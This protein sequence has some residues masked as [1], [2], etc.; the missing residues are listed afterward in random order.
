MI[1]RDFSN[2]QTVAVVTD[3][4]A[5]VP[6]GDAE[7]LG[8]SIVPFSVHIENEEFL[9]G[10]DLPPRLLYQRMC[11]EKIVPRTSAPSPADYLNVFRSHLD[12]GIQAIIQLC[13]SS[14]LSSAYNNACEAAKRA[15]E[16][17]PGRSVK[18][19]DTLLAAIPQGFIVM[20]AAER[21]LRGDS[22]SEILQ[23]VKKSVHQCGL[24]A[25]PGT[26]EYLARGGRIGK[27]AFLLGSMVKI[28]PILTLEEGVVSPIRN[29]R[30]EKRALEAIIDYVAKKL[31]GHKN[32]QAAILE[33]DDAERAL[34]LR[35]L[36]LEKLNPAKIIQTEFTPVM[37][38]H[39]G[40]GLVGLAYFYE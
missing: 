31:Q 6:D 33:A 9:D 19:I 40:P 2:L 4:V 16:E 32:F 13:L 24:A 34:V 10:V 1:G 27:A 23:S 21:A 37:G 29:V 26:L 36:V 11:E 17:F 35:D 22:L 20:D 12:K 15:C 30:T 28:K 8:V 3:S 5:Q 25:T 14:K 18:V 7:R 39:T 38:V